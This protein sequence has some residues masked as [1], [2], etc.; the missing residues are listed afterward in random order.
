MQLGR[1]EAV[2]GAAGRGGINLPLLSHAG[3]GR[4]SHAEMQASETYIRL[5]CQFDPDSVLDFLQSHESY[6]VQV[7]FLSCPVNSLIIAK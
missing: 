1:E 3:I 2:A 7:R 6:R 4:D 5:L